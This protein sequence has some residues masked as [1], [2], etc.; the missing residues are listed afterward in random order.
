MSGETVSCKTIRAVL[1]VATAAGL[2]P[3]TLLASRGIDPATVADP[4]A[5]FPHDLWIG[6]WRDVDAS[7]PGAF[8]LRAA[9]SLP[10]DH[11]DVID[12]VMAASDDLRSGLLLFQRYFAL[13]S[14]GVEHVVVPDGENARLERRYRDATHTTIPHPAEFAFA[15]VVIRARRMTQSSFRPIAVHFAHRRPADDREHREIF[16]CPLHFD[17]HVSA[18]LFDKST[19]ALPTRDPKPELRRVLERHADAL[20]AA[21]P[22]PENDL[23]TLVKQ[24]IVGGLKTGKSGL[25]DVAKK[26]GTSER[27]LQRRLGEI[28]TTHAKLLDE[29]RTELATRYLEEPSLAI[30]EVA[31]LLG[32]A[33]VSAFHRAFRRWTDRTPAEHR[34]L[35]AGSHR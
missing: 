3:K 17:A 30:A 28:D 11:F 16:D 18:I 14:T 31:F 9:K 33:D 32:F 8:G 5:R 12:Y 25:A 27:T 22:N 34:R 24:A 1:A 13:V 21:L 23:K 26:L 2:D 29:A 19:L 20:L 4:D 35:A 10:D 6:L 7:G 15:C